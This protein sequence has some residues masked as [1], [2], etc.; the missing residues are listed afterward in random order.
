MSRQQPTAAPAAAR[1]AGKRLPTADLERWE[2]DPAR[3]SLTFVLRHLVVSEIRGRFRRWGGTLF[4]DRKEPLLSSLRVWVDLA[5]IDTDS[6]ERDEHIRSN[7]FLDVTRF[8]RAE[9]VS[10]SVEPRDGHVLVRGRLAL[11]DVVHDVEVEVDPFVPP[12]PDGTTY[13]VR[14]RLDRQSFG[15]HWNQDLDVGGV[16]VSDEIAVT[17]ELVLVRQNGDAKAR[18]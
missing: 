6:A 3:S 9:L 15:L 8:P 17:A 14:G 5:T 16:V 12:T 4:F 11:H 13:Q 1:E 7:E 10:T 2:I 18:S